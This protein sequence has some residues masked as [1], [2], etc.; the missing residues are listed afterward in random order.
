MEAMGSLDSSTREMMMPKLSLLWLLSLGSATCYKVGLNEAEK[1]LGHLVQKFPVEWGNLPQGAKLDDISH[2]PLVNVP[3]REARSALRVEEINKLDDL[4]VVPYQDT[5]QAN[6]YCT[7]LFLDYDA[8]RPDPNNVDKYQVLYMAWNS[9]CSGTNLPEAYDDATDPMTELFAYPANG[10]G[11]IKIGTGEHKLYQVL[12]KQPYQ[13]DN[14]AAD[15]GMH[16]ARLRADGIFGTNDDAN[17]YVKFDLSLFK[18]TYDMEAI[19][20]AE[21]QYTNECDH[22]S[23]KFCDQDEEC[24]TGSCDELNCDTHCTGSGAVPVSPITGHACDCECPADLVEQSGGPPGSGLNCLEC[25]TDTDCDSDEACSGGNTCG[26][27]TCATQCGDHGYCKSDGNHGA[28]CECDDGYYLDT[29]NGSGD[30]GC[31]A[32]PGGIPDDFTDEDVVVIDNGSKDDNDLSMVP[33][34]DFS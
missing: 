12:L 15:R 28:E 9:K 24:N 19:Y 3:F 29:D 34:I 27:V 1:D 8:P 13:F 26:D 21:C 32:V 17:S 7:Y 23:G 5:Y 31:V 2:V 22:S 16:N 4:E 20:I 18:S 14:Q 30:G 33:N 6:E 11:A 10:A 25:N